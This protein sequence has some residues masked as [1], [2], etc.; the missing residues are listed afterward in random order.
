MR[1]GVITCEFDATGHGDTN[2]AD[3]RIGGEH[4]ADPAVDDD[5]TARTSVL[6][7]WCSVMRD[8]DDCVPAAPEAIN[9]T[10]GCRCNS[11]AAT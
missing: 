8:S 1:P 9:R 3:G 10:C 5:V 6:T 2:R 4:G 11:Y 7:G